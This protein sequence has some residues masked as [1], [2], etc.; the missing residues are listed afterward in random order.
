MIGSQMCGFWRFSDY[1]RAN[2]RWLSDEL[3]N[4]LKQDPLGRG[5][6]LTVKAQVEI[7]LYRLGHGSTHVTIGH[8]FSIGT[9]MADKAAS[10]LDGILV[11]K[12]MIIVKYMDSNPLKVVCPV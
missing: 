11:D 7:G 12:S 6:P 1:P 5:Q 3:C 2:F 9:Q 4:Q 10:R 8:V